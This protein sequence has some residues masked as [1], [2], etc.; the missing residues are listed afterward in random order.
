[1]VRH[2]DRVIEFSRY[3]Y[4]GNK[5]NLA[6]Y[7]GQKVLLSFFRGASCPFCNLRIRQLIIQYPEF[8]KNNIEII[9]LF[10]ASR[11]EI[12]EYAGKQN[13][14]FPIIPDPELDL[15]IKYGIEEGY[16]G[17]FRVMLKPVEL[18]KVM[19]SGFFNLKTIHKKP[20]LPADFLID[21]NQVVYRV[22]YGKDYGDHVPV[23]DVLTWTNNHI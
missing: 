22:Y 16:S 11:E 23:E 8:K 3:D 9:A 19:T 17:L 14:P 4:L 15:Y 1:M 7:R 20:I 13:A 10:A 6:D 18:F 2:N 5:I 21:E 12:L